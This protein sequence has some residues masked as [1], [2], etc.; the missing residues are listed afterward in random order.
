MVTDANDDR[1]SRNFESK[2]TKIDNED[3]AGKEQD[4]NKEYNFLQIA[5]NDP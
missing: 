2:I 5:G 3:Q 1:Y 4:N